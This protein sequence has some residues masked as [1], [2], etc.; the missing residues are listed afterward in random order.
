MCLAT[1]PVIQT[2]MITVHGAK[3]P[4]MALSGTRIRW[5]WDGHPIVTGIGTGS[6]PG[7]GPGW[8]TRRGA[9]RHFT[10]AAGHLL[11]ADGAGA[12]DQSLSVRSMDRRSSALS[13]EDI[14]DSGSALAEALA[15]ESA[16]SRWASANR[17]IPG[18][19][20]ATVTSG[21]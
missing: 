3:S 16:G 15:A 20:P 17:S 7:A 19:T 13:A 6:A 11:A 4:T 10:M 21:T 14:S 18:I 5:P 8:T 2:W 9:L 12:R 1:S